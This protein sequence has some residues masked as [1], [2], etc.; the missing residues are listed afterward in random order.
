LPDIDCKFFFRIAFISA[1][2]SFE[3]RI[4]SSLYF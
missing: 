3:R 4:F 1:L 2:L